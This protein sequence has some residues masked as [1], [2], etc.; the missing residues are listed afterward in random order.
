M[1]GAAVAGRVR[2]RISVIV[3]ALASIVATDCLLLPCLR[4]SSDPFFQRGWGDI[5]FSI[6]RQNNLLFAS[7]RDYPYPRSPDELVVGIF[8]GSV[9]KNFALDMED[10]LSSIRAAHA[11]GD[12]RHRRVRV[13][14]LAVSG[15]SEPSQFNLLHLLGDQI[16]VAV[17]LDG[18]NELFSD[19]T[20]CDEFEK[21]WAANRQ[22]SDAIL[23]PILERSK[24]LRSWVTSAWW[25]LAAYSGTF[26][27]L[28][29]RESVAL[30]DLSDNFF[31]NLGVVP[32]AFSRPEPIVARRIERWARCVELSARYA[33][34]LKLP[35]LF[36]VQPSQYLPDAK[37]LTVQER[38]QCLYRKEEI[39][40]EWDLYSALPDAYAMYDQHI[41]ALRGEGVKVE[42]LAG[43]FRATEETVFIDKC[44]HVNPRGNEIMAEEIFR[45]VASAISADG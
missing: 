32:T 27:V 38:E 5:T 17:F 44:C 12:R 28:L 43:V 3:F 40:L 9:A 11:L 8:G 36:F 4:F 39:P 34:S 30:N 24:R 6:R 23:S 37:P 29:Y 33:G 22:S 35:I 10:G 45:V 19:Q 20:S 16:D 2:R 41:A 13:E 21:F 18:F 15:N 26:R 1:S 7:P 42:S 14:N 25:P 31:R